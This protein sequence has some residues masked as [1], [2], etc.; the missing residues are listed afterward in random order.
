MQRPVWR[1][2]TRLVERPDTV[3]VHKIDV[4]CIRCNPT[5]RGLVSDG[6][7]AED[8]GTSSNRLK[9]GARFPLGFFCNAQEYEG[10]HV[11][12]E[13]WAHRAVSAQLKR[14]LTQAVQRK[15]AGGYR[16]ESRP[17]SMPSREGRQDHQP[18][19]HAA[20]DHHSHYLRNVEARVA[21]PVLNAQG[22]APDRQR[23]LLRLRAS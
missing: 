2:L 5:A 7:G 15:V 8:Q 22:R 18:Q 23:R 12:E 11:R 3:A 20:P 9:E 4:C 1:G 19:P 21:D 13:P 10:I 16:V 17:T 14:N 6:S